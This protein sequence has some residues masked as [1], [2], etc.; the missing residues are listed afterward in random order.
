MYFSGKLFYLD[1]DKDGAGCF[2]KESW[3]AYYYRQTGQ[4]FEQES[5]G[6]CPRGQ[7]FAFNA[8][9]GTTEC[10]C[11]KNFA[12]NPAD[13]TCVEKFTKGPCPEGEVCKYVYIYIYIYIYIYNIDL[14]IFTQINNV[15]LYY[16]AACCCQPTRK[17]AEL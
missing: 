12:F 4:C 8:T 11:F 15:N 14:I 3:Q 13:G 5:K 17:C 6:P 1:Q 2:C 7:Y 16:Y 9:S 10:N